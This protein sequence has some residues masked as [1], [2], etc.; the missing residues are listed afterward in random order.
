MRLRSISIKN[1]LDIIA[2]EFISNLPQKPFSTNDHTKSCIKSHVRKVFIICFK[3]G[4]NHQNRRGA[5]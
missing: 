5:I 2:K 1:D 4:D 3:V